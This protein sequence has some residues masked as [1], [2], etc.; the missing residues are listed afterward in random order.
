MDQHCPLPTPSAWRRAEK[1]T[2][3]NLWLFLSISTGHQ[4]PLPT[5]WLRAPHAKLRRTR[6]FDLFFNFGVNCQEQHPAVTSPR[7]YFALNLSCRTIQ[8]CS[9][10]APQQLS[11]LRMSHTHGQSWLS[12]FLIDFY[13]KTRTIRLRST[14][15]NRGAHH[16]S[17]V[18]L[19]TPSGPYT[20]VKRHQY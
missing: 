11:L 6:F 14:L 9:S 1:E 19:E 10:P 13:N 18:P 15:L 5:Q 16:R 20:E 8:N 3:G 17:L 4:Q 7:H 12:A 2:H